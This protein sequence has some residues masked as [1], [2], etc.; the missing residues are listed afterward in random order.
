MTFL[1]MLTASVILGWLAQT[2]KGRVG[3]KWA[4]ISMVTMCFSW[5]FLYFFISVVNPGFFKGDPEVFALAILIIAGIGLIMGIVIWSLPGKGGTASAKNS[6]DPGGSVVVPMQ[7]TLIADRKERPCPWCAEQILVAAK[8]CKH[9]GRDV[10]VATVPTPPVESSRFKKRS[11]PHCEKEI[12][13]HPSRVV[14]TCPFCEN[15]LPDLPKE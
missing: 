2:K 8:V 1:M 10:P 15:D 9:C 11:C 4:L 13:Y 6:A 3:A 14:R 7:Q 5:M 12:V